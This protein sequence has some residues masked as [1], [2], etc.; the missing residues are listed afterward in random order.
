[1]VASLSTALLLAGPASA[2]QLQVAV[3][4]ESGPALV[5]QLAQ[6]LVVGARRTAAMLVQGNLGYLHLHG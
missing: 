6:R 5:V 3:G 4:A 1:M 2:G